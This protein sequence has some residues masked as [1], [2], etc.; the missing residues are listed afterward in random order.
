[1]V[2]QLFWLVNN[3]SNCLPF[4]HKHVCYMWLRC[5]FVCIYCL[6]I[7]NSLNFLVAFPVVY[8]MSLTSDRTTTLE[9]QLTAGSFEALCFIYGKL[10]IPADVSSVR[11]C[12]YVSHYLWMGRR[13]GVQF[14]DWPLVANIEIKSLVR[15]FRARTLN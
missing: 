14:W 1:M 6:A 4:T 11:F 5:N 7:Q 12:I 3:K 9:G 15:I 2:C 8:I 10:N 13:G